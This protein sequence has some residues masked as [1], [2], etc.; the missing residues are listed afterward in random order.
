MSDYQI[1]LLPKDNYYDWVEAAK[2]YVIKFGPNLTPDPDSAGRFMTPQQVITIA[3][4]PNG[5]PAQGDI[6][7]WFRANYP[8]VRTDFIEAPT[9]SDFQVAL[10][11]RLTANDRYLQPGAEFKLLWPTEYT[12]VNQPFGVHPEVYRRFGLP[13][14]EGVDLRAPRGSKIFAGADGTV[15]VADEY[16]G[17][18]NKQP[19][20][21]SVRI[22]H[23]DGYL[24]VYAHL[25][26]IL[27]KVGDVVRAGQVIGL[28]DSTGNS[29]GD[30]LHLTLKKTGATAAGLTNFPKDILDPTPFLIW[31]EPAGSSS[32]TPPLAITTYP[33][34]A[35]V[36]LVGVNGRADGPMQD[37]DFSAC[38]QSRIEA[39]K[40]QSSARP[41]NVDRLRSINPN[42]F[43]MVRLFSA[44]QGRVIRP[45]EFAS[46]LSYD[47]GQFYQ[48]G[49]RYFELHNEPN[50]Q[51]EGW[52]SSWKDGREFGAWFIETMNHLK[53][54]YPEAKIGFPG[55]S[56]G[57][58]I[59]GQRLDAMT[60]LS[61][62]DEAARAADWVALHC[63]WQNETEMN[64]P[65][66][67][68][69]YL[70]YR[71]RFPDKL[72]FITEFSN[73]AQAVD[74]RIKGQDYVRYY[75]KVRNVSG[76]G[77]AFSFTVSASSFFAFESW[78]EENGMLSEI[79][80]LV[81]GRS[82]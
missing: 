67:G 26:Q 4:L 80:K 24:T 16:R 65:A 74:K 7:T 69:A 57:A 70:E 18:V 23:R 2:E 39:V 55:L 11:A 53:R 5:Y 51:L 9:P 45:D 73:V 33:W 29:T 25:V 6:Q 47:M 63:Y 68:A 52:T 59:P 71:R 49:V 17:D 37:P 64:S 81:G 41:E 72:L 32:S 35:G 42:M 76:L 54:V 15:V 8:S 34:P 46:W 14:H 22:Q 30:H 20:G 50:L 38:T 66:D 36:C 78:R 77:A 43:I 75:Q 21:N 48:R 13:G 40:L 1:L 27:V 58:G 19:Y 10:Q 79:P 31:P 61:D 12:V 62:A 56:P 3:G 28:A 60:F 82:F 44:F